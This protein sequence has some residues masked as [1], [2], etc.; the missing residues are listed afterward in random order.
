VDAEGVDVLGGQL[1]LFQQLVQVRRDFEQREVEH[2]AAVHKEHAI[3]DFQVRGTGAVG[4]EFGL[5]Q[6]PG[7][8]FAH[9]GSGSGV[10][11][12]HG[13]VAVFGINDFRI[14]VGSDQ[15][16][17]FQAS[18]F[19]KTFHRVDA[20]DITRA[21]QG[22]IKGSHIGRQTE[23]VLNDGGR[24][25]Q[26]FGIAVLGNDDQRVD[27]FALELR[28]VG[29]QRVDRF[30]T[31]IRG[32]LVSIFARQKSRTYLAQNKFFVLGEFRAL[33]VVVYTACW[34]VTGDAF[35]ANHCG[36]PILNSWR[37]PA[38]TIEGC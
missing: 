37:S 3:A 4:A 24:V 28:I 8:V 9:P 33:R 19:H 13:G 21:T 17:V 16:A 1:G 5:A 34:H 2:L 27:G 6:L 23:F 18:G 26:A 20:V 25:R 31:Q 15:Q 14:R 35:N 10:A 12:E 36:F 38:R 29:E 22:N 30:D 11:E 7:S 32:F